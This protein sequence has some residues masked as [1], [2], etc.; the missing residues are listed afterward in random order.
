MAGR[1]LVV[2]ALGAGLLL[3]GA[4]G[5]EVTR[6]AFNDDSGVDTRITKIRISNDSG[7]V[8]LRAG[9][10]TTVHRTVHYDRDRPGATHHVDGDALVIDSCPVRNCWIDYEVTVP[11]GTRVDGSIDSGHIEIDGL[12]AVNLKVSSGDVRMRGIS[13]QVNLDSESGMIHLSDVGDA[14]V[15]RSE[16]GDVTVDNARA[17]VTVQAE[18]GMVR[19]DGVAG[20]VD[21]RSHSGNVSVRLSTAQNIRAQADSGMVTVAVPRAAYRVSTSADGGK[22]RSDVAD[23]PS[24]THQLELHADSGDITLSYT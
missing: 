12:A 13:G 1:G 4:C 10:R 7:D 15:V 16:S 8:K 19:A 20:A 22:V 23:D 3:L 11:A 24:G 17:G 18:S 5:W 9:D 14:V 2:A 6:N 21:V